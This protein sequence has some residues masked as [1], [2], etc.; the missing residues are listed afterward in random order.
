MISSEAHRQ[1]VR[2]LSVP[3]GTTTYPG[4]A[5]Y[6]QLAIGTALSEGRFPVVG[7]VKDPT[8]LAAPFLGSAKAT[9][10]AEIEYREC[11]V[12]WRRFS[13]KNDGEQI[14]DTAVDVEKAMKSV[15]GTERRRRCSAFMKE[16]L[17]MLVEKSLQIAWDYLDGSGE[18]HDQQETA[19]ILL[20]AIQS[21]VL[22]GEGRMLMLSNRAIAV[23]RQQRQVMAA[24]SPIARSAM[25]SD[26]FVKTTRS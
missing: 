7:F 5:D 1:P 4:A 11:Y 13:M 10:T 20:T 16:P 22:R 15:E 12:A 23:Y 14:V 3:I 2:S 6:W 25:A 19:E 24:S 26:G 18:I 9:I 17:P 21:Q 8:G